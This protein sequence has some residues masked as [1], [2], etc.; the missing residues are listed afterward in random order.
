MII[1]GGTPH[2]ERQRIG[3]IFSQVPVPLF[4][5]ISRQR[6]I[7]NDSV[8]AVFSPGNNEK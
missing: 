6:G 1:A 7:W 5:P 3:T 8:T 4:H 2:T